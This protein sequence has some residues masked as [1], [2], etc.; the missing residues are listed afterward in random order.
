MCSVLRPDAWVNGQMRRRVDRMVRGANPR[1]GVAPSRWRRVESGQEACIWQCF[2]GSLNAAARSALCS[3]CVS[4]P[5][6]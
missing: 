1:Q 2:L 4:L 3:S 6:Q 5:P